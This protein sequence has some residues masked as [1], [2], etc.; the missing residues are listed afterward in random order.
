MAS[1]SYFT[2]MAGI[3]YTL[4]VFAL[5]PVALTAKVNFFGFPFAEESG[6]INLA[7][8]PNLRLDEYFNRN[9]F[10]QEIELPEST[11]FIFFQIPYRYIYVS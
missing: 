7:A 4:L 6:D 5:V 8:N 9:P 1:P 2:V 3:V 11:P 10:A